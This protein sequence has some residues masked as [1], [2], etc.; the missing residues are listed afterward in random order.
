LLLAVLGCVSDVALG[1]FNAVAFYLDIG[2]MLA[3]EGL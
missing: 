1:R 2:D 3:R